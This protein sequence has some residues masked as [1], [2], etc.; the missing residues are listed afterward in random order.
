[1][2][3]MFTFFL[4]FYCQ[5]KVCQTRDELEALRKVHVSLF[6]MNAVQFRELT[7]CLQPC[8]HQ[9]ANYSLHFRSTKN[10]NQLISEVHVF[11][12]KNEPGVIPSAIR[13][14][15]HHRACHQP[16]L[17]QQENGLP[18]FVSQMF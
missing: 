13:R 10:L 18:I 6:D 5:A 7:N 4:I 15:Q 8:M 16:L 11:H 17:N 1:M 9:V 14:S 12:K 2:Y 3:K